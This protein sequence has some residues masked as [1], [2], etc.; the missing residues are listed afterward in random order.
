MA[1]HLRRGIDHGG[2]ADLDKPLDIDVII[3][4]AGFGGVYLLH[5]F[6]KNGY[7]AKIIEAG[8]DL[9]GIWHWNCYPGARVDSDI[10]LYEFSIP[11]VWSTWTW[12]ERFPSFTELRKYFAHV[13]HVLDIKK[14]A[15]F[16]TKV[17]GAQ[18]NLASNRWKVTT[19][20]GK[21]STCRFFVVAGGI[22]AKRHFPNWK[23]IDSFKG[24]IH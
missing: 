3:V 17:V 14:D 11:E 15:I 19:E 8:S 2:A 4:G 10:P 22:A 6:R 7:S 13:D 5:N 24:D 9:G 20:D 23:G 12:Q 21:V 18:F 16:N 1:T